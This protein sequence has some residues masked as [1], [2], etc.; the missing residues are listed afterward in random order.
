M[1]SVRSAVD[2][3]DVACGEGYGA[4]MLG[5]H[6]ILYGA[7]I[8]FLPPFS[9]IW[10]IV[11]RRRVDVWAWAALPVFSFFVLYAFHD[12][13]TRLIETLVGGQRL[14]AVGYVDNAE[15]AMAQVNTAR[16]VARRDMETRSI[17]TTVLDGRSH[18][19]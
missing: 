11:A 17:R 12:R 3:L 1:T 14:V 16:P 15:P 4:A 7:G 18:S 2:V 9:F 8:C 19:F 10:L 6:L 13:S 5:Q